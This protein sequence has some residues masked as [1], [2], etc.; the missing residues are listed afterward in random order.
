MV[1]R[2]ILQDLEA[3][4]STVSDPVQGA[5]PTKGLSV[6]EVQQRWQMLAFGVLLGS[7]LAALPASIRKPYKMCY[8]ISR[9]HCVVFGNKTKLKTSSLLTFLKAVT[10]PLGM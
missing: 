8:S 7:V 9:C 6:Y 10:F 5:P 2:I 3:G 1:W 4:M